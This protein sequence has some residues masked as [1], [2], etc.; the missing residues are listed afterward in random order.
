VNPSDTCFLWIDDVELRLE[1]NESPESGVYRYLEGVVA[2]AVA[3]HQLLKPDLAKIFK[4]TSAS[5]VF[6]TGFRSDVMSTDDIVSGLLERYPNAESF[7]QTSKPY[8]ESKVPSFFHGAIHAEATLMGLISYLNPNHEHNVYGRD[9]EILNEDSFNLESFWPV[10]CLFFVPIHNQHI[11]F[12]ALAKKPAIATGNKCCWCCQKISQLI[13][14]ISIP[15]SHGVIYPWCPPQIGISLATLEVLETKL[16]ERLYDELKN[17]H[18]STQIID[19]S[20][21]MCMSMSD[22]TDNIFEFF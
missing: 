21:D 18:Y 4:A 15:G 6:V 17:K 14:P 11:Y 12:Q 7:M 1:P 2:W 19:D 16:W 8:L 3:L 9:A 10:C 5:V 22:E 13:G 20:E